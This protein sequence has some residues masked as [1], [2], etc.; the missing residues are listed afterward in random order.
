MDASAAACRLLA[1]GF[2][3]IREQFHVPGVFPA[4]A[5]A[6]A[7]GAATAQHHDDRVDGRDLPI[8]TLD[9]AGSMDL[10]QAFALDV[11]G[12]DIVL[13]YAIADVAAF[14]AREGPLAEEVWQRGVTVYAPD[15]RV[16]L[17]PPV[18]SEGA[19]SLLPAG[20]RLSVLLTVI[21]D[22]EGTCRVAVG[23]A[24]VVRSRAKLAYETVAPAQL[25]PLLDELSRRMSAA[26]DRR[27]AG[28]IEFPAPEIVVDPSVPGGLTVRAKPRA[29]SEDLNANLS[30]R[31]QPGGGGAD[32][33]GGSRPVPGDGRRSAGELRPSPP[34]GEGTPR[35]VAGWSEPARPDRPARSFGRRAG[36]FPAGGAPSRRRGHLRHDRR[37]SA[38]AQRDRRALR[39]R[40]RAV[41]AAGRPLRPG[42][43][44]RAGGGR[45]NPTTLAALPALAEVMERAETMA[46][47]VDRAAIDLVEAVILRDRAGEVFRATVIDRS[48]DRTRIQLADPPVRASVPADNTAPGEELDVRLTEADV[49]QRRL[50]F[51]VA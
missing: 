30:A 41:A 15:G 17:H 20:D 46:A 12:D 28:R 43:G 32:A 27:G 18:L 19:A 31:R 49:P 26:E 16:P 3:A 34:R 42:P 5:M 35:G 22:G 7:V 51:A 24:G 11:E 29:P 14:V 6:E 8:V 4:A 33:R 44:L 23:R 50:D 13:S 1:D 40:H 47:G 25:P 2:A 45:A 10:D 38:V 9:P 39:P 48:G 21:V 36:R 37:R